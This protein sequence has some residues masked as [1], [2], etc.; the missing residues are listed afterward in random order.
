MRK[1][2]YNNLQFRWYTGVSLP[3]IF[4]LDQYQTVEPTLDRIFSTLDFDT[5]WANLLIPQRTN[6][7]ILDG[8]LDLFWKGTAKQGQ[9]ENSR[10]LG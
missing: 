7:E 4:K 5:G 1:G 8:V 2:K 3:E 6:T 10:N 9:A